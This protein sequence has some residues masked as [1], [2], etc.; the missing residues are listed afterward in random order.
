MS[1]LPRR[2]APK[3]SRK[4][5]RK[6]KP[7]KFSNGPRVPPLRGFTIFLDSLTHRFR[8]GLRSAAPTGLYEIEQNYLT[9]KQFKL[10]VH[11]PLFTAG[12]SAFQFTA[13]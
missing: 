1:L 11:R 4:S 12:F 2:F 7:E 6:K 3:P 9:Y 5:G 8:G 13:S 10:S